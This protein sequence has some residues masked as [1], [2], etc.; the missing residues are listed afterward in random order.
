MSQLSHDRR[1][2]PDAFGSLKFQQPHAAREMRKAHDGLFPPDRA[3]R[4]FF[5]VNA[6]QPV[7]FEPVLSRQECVKAP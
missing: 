4:D 5:P 3:G 1:E 2:H 6:Y 7:G